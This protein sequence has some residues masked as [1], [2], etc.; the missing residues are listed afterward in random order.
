MDLRQATRRST[1][2]SSIL[3]KGTI[4]NSNILNSSNTHNNN[5]RSNTISVN[6]SLSTIIISSPD[7]SNSNSNPL[8]PKSSIFS[9]SSKSKKMTK[10][11]SII[12]SFRTEDLEGLL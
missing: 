2:I 12:S 8:H 6:N 5:I 9:N 4:S 1:R 11:L 7:I 10:I 3:S